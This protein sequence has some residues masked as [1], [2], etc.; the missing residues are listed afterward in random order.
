MGTMIETHRMARRRFALSVLLASAYAGVA[1]A[2][3]NPGLGPISGTCARCG[4][5]EV[6]ADGVIGVIDQL[7][8][9]APDARVQILRFDPPELT[10]GVLRPNETATRTERVTNLA[11]VP[12][13]LL[14]VSVSAS[15][16]S[17][18]DGPVVPLT[19]APGEQV[20]FRVRFQPK[21]GVYHSGNLEVVTNES[22]R[23]RKVSL[24]GRASISD[25]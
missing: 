6:I 25:R 9:R 16:F 19:L 24:L 13:R 18:V 10:F 22:P 4:A 12:L 20:E 3:A 7:P 8:S 11:G 23:A 21:W 14:A 1:C 2:H 5:V 15:A 17:L